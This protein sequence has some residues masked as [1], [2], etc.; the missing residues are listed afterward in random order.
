M[1]DWQTSYKS[2]I[3]LLKGVIAKFICSLFFCAVLSLPGML[4]GCTA[5]YDDHSAAGTM[6][7][8]IFTAEFRA[9]G[10]GRGNEVWGRLTDAGN[11]LESGLISR[12]IEN[13]EL[14]QINASAGCEEGWPVSEE[15]E[16]Y[17]ALCIRL[18]QDTEGAFDISI[19]AL[20]ELWNMDEAAANPE[21]F[22]VPN[23]ESIAEA[24]SVSG[25][26]KIR[27]ENHRIYIPE[28]MKLD[29]GAIGKGIYLTNALDI[30]KK[31]ASYGVISAGGS[32]LTYGS[33]PGN[34]TWRVGIV[35]PLDTSKTKTVIK[36][37]GINY[38]STS[39]DYERFVEQDGIRYHHILNPLTGYPADSSV[40]SVTVIVSGDYENASIRE[41]SKY[42]GLLSDAISTAV[43]VLGEEKGLVLAKEYGVD[44]LI[45]RNDG[46][47]SMTEEINNN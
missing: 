46:S 8:T 19:G 11:E 37:E 32:I 29:M 3:R 5:G 2:K 39:G 30:L 4:V 35:D 7:G 12:R 18:S 15:L 9:R 20:T 41:G 13:S 22:I 25:Y 26:E 10:A 24:L 14:A 36:V 44:I 34:S 21:A 1:T 16:D 31:E 6:M 40:R 23:E 33:R 43:F 42:A 27:I 45:V 47:M 38:I 28:G 17:I